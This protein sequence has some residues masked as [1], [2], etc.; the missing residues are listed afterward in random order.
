MGV[1]QG[2]SEGQ[3][4]ASWS[5]TSVTTSASHQRQQRQDISPDFSLRINDL[6]QAGV[7]TTY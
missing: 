2:A 6:R 1:R 4:G 7:K 3:C 5:A